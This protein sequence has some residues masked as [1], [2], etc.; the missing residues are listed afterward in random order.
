MARLVFRCFKPMPTSHSAWWCSKGSALGEALCWTSGAND[1]TWMI[2]PCV[3]CINAVGGKLKILKLERNWCVAA[4]WGCVGLA[5]WS[6]GSCAQPDLLKKNTCSHIGLCS[7]PYV[8]STAE[9]LRS[10]T[11]TAGQSWRVKCKL[12]SIDDRG[13]GKRR[14]GRV[15]GECW[16]HCD[17]DLI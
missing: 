5:R 17:V 11:L 8:T 4:L 9:S 6:A 15:S 10:V 7:D 16:V 12:S 2:Q 13:E 14:E 3:I 1:T